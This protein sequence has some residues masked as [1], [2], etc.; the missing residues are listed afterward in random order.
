MSKNYSYMVI[1]TISGIATSRHA[2][3]SAAIKAARKGTSRK[4]LEIR[5]YSEAYFKKMKV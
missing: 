3:E 1:E 4:P 2:S 5:E